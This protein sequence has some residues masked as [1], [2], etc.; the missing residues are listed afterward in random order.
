MAAQHRSGGHET[1][2]RCQRL[3]PFALSCVSAQAYPPETDA[4]NA[5][6]VRRGH[7]PQVRTHARSLVSLLLPSACPV[8]HARRV[9]V[10]VPFP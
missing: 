6:D 2:H 10:Y 9:P 5:Q 7:D 1:R 4:T 3:T 8:R